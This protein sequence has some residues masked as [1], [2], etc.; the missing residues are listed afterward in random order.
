[1]QSFYYP[2]ALI[3]TIAV[4][5]EQTLQVNPTHKLEFNYALV[6]SKNS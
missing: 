3:A 2:K 6:N 1:M 4:L 5:T